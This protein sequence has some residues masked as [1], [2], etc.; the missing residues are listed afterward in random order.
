MKLIE[1]RVEN[2]KC[3]EDSQP[4]GV[5]Q[6]TCLVGKNEAGKSALL[7]ALYKMNPVEKEKHEFHEEEYP[8]RHLATYRQR[9][10]RA[11]ANVLTTVWELEQL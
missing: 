3:V 8:R 4:F 1:A 10:E 9:Q 11:S 7:E 5:D 6:V 2:F